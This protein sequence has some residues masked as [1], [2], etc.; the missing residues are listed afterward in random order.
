M[1]YQEYKMER[2]TE[3]EN[4]LLLLCNSLVAWWTD[5]IYEVAVG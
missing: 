3:R 1:C 2:D 4:G 5:K